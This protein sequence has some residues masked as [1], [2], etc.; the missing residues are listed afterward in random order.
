MKKGIESH[1]D[2]VDVE[3][4]WEIAKSLGI[5]EIK[6]VYF[7]FH[8][9]EKGTP[10]INYTDLYLPDQNVAVFKYRFENVWEKELLLNSLSSR[11]VRLPLQVTWGVGGF[12]APFGTVVIETSRGDFKIHLTSYGM[13]MNQ[14]WAINPNPTFESYT[15][16]RLLDDIYFRERGRHLPKV[17]FDKISGKKHLDDSEVE[18]LKAI[19][20][21][22][23]EISK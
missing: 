10:P 9:N 13:S 14:E 18:Y 22:T 4:G 23:I 15:L 19:E 21:A 7:T 11:S 17:V 20:E 3:K 5:N 8:E 2:A 12:N 16:A 1:S 6:S